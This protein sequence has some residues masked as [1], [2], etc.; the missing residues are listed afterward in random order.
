MTPAFATTLA[1]A[2]DHFTQRP[3]DDKKRNFLT[4]AENTIKEMTSSCQQQ[5]KRVKK[6]EDSAIAALMKSA[7][8]ETETN[9]KLVRDV[10]ESQREQ[11]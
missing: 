6:E 3:S 1:A 10:I 8:E 5:D 7:D 4:S 2:L 11:K 9:S